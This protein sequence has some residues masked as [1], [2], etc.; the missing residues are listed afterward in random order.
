[1]SA[2]D[3]EL[4]AARDV[5]MDHV[6]YILIMF[7]S[8][9][10]L[11]TIHSVLTYLLS[12]SL[13]FLIYTFVV[14]LINLWATSGRNASSTPGSSSETDRTSGEVEEAK[15]YQRVP[16]GEQD[17]EVLNSPFVIGEDR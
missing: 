7:R 13:A 4:H 2:I 8:I 16:E 12:S 14:V 3:E 11:R 10:L 17:A 9:A 6:T 1:M 15:W 5:G